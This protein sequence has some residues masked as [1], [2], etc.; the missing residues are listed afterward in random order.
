LVCGVALLVRRSSLARS[1]AAKAA[2]PHL[3]AAKPKDEPDPDDGAENCHLLLLTTSLDV[4]VQR[5]SPP[6]AAAAQVA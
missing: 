6:C 2:Q 4:L 5:S 3:L 1:G